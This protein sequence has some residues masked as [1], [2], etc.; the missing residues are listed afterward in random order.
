MR[1]FFDC[2]AHFTDPRLGICFW[3]EDQ[4]EVERIQTWKWQAMASST[5]SC[6][7]HCIL[8]T[9]Q[10]VYQSQAQNMDY[11]LTFKARLLILEKNTFNSLF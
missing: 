11:F 6:L 8:G 10:N 9:L 4:G 2:L 3:S 1:F 7:Q 5:F